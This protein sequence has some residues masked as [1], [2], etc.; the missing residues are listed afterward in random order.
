MREFVRVAPGDPL[1][2]SSADG[3]GI[4]LNGAFRAAERHIDN[5]AFVGH[6][7]GKRAHLVGC[8]VRAVAD[9]SLDRVFVVAVLRAPGFDHLD[10]AVVELHWEVEVGNRVD[11]L[12]LI[13]EPLWKAGEHGGPVEISAQRECSLRIRHLGG[14]GVSWRPGAV[15]QPL[16]LL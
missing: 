1:E 14:F 13:Q 12:D 16:R 5:R 8:D 3:E 11:G 9:A 15:G 6:E 2:H 4:D 7:C 10:A